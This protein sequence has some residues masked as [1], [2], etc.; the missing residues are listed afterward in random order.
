MAI[1]KILIVDDSATDR[2]Y[3]TDLLEGAGYQVIALESGE[4]CVEHR[5]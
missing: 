3:L 2:F 1:S 5:R 4:A